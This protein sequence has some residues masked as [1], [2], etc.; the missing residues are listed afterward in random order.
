MKRL[1]RSKKGKVL[2]G[3]CVGIGN[4]FNVDPVVIRVIWIFL[5]IPG[6]LPGIIPYVLC[7][8]IIPKEE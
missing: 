6:G 3:V 2:A 5:L 7:W 4:Y 8:I 1:V